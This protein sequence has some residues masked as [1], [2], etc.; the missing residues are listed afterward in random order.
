MYEIIVISLIYFFVF[1]PDL[2]DRWCCATSNYKHAQ[3]N[4]TISRRKPR[5]SRLNS[6]TKWSVKSE[7]SFIH[8][9]TVFWDSATLF[10]GDIWYKIQNSVFLNYSLPRIILKG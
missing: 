9:Y 6:K 8:L 5:V 4:L 2:T 3:N 7:W 1:V 10:V